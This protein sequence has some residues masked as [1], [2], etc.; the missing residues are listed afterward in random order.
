MENTYYNL[1]QMKLYWHSA[2]LDLCKNKDKS[3][4]NKKF[5]ELDS[6]YGGPKRYYHTFQHIGNMFEMVNEIYNNTI[7]DIYNSGI[8][9]SHLLTATFFHDAIYEVCSK[10][11]VFKSSLLAMSMLESLGVEY[12]DIFVIQDLIR[13]TDNHEV[14]SGGMERLVEVPEIFQKI[15]IDADNAILSSGK[16]EYSDYARSIKDEYC[17]PYS[18]DTFIQGRKEF[19][20]KLLK[21]GTIFL[22][23]YMNRNYE[24]KARNNIEAELN[25]L[26][27]FGI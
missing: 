3:E 8:N 20:S 14:N 15:F 22:T 2:V 17:P 10:D 11:C 23:V 13:I 16:S 25:E 27:I 9:K 7:Y 21:R 24:E 19:L 4:I 1:D 5:D 18:K 6:Y 12:K 26:K